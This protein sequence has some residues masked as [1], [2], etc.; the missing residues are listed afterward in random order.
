LVLDSHVLLGAKSVKY[1]VFD[2]GTTKSPG[3]G[4]KTFWFWLRLCGRAKGG[5]EVMLKLDVRLL[6]ILVRS[7]EEFKLMQGTVF[8]RLEVE[9]Q[10]MIHATKRRA[11]DRVIPVG[12]VAKPRAEQSLQLTF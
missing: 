10:L 6:L 5:F 4:G 11:R 1:V 9:T 3:V 2:R 12:Y 8:M 7:T